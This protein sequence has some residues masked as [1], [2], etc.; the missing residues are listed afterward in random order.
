MG[1]SPDDSFPNGSHSI[2]YRG[3]V[4]WRA[5]T[6][7]FISESIRTDVGQSD[8]CITLAK[9]WPRYNRCQQQAHSNAYPEDQA[10]LDTRNDPRNI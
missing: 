6:S 8:I 1:P 3:G 2:P 10:L 9:I 7:K 4:L 5:Q